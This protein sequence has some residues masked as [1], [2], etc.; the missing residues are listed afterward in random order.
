MSLLAAMALLSQSAVGAG[1][2]P[3]WSLVV[4]R[5]VSTREP[6]SIRQADDVVTIGASYLGSFDQAR[7][8]TGPP[9]DQKFVA[10]LILLE[11]LQDQPVLLL[12]MKRGNDGRYVVEEWGW[13]EGAGDVACLT[14]PALAQIKW[15]STPDGVTHWDDKVCVPLS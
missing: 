12:L 1:E 13:R 14:H 6:R 10:R 7:V 11:P 5:A 4:A 3:T 15:A 9:V 2:A 8:V